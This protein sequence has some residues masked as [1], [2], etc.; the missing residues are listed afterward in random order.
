MVLAGVIF[1]V[2]VAF[3][4]VEVGLVALRLLLDVLLVLVLFTSL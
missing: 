1:L 2:F 3:R 4:Q